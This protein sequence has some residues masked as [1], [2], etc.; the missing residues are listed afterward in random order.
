[1]K[2]VVGV[3]RIHLDPGQGP[4]ADSFYH[5]NESSLSIKDG[6]KVKLSLCLTKLYA[7]KA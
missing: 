2:L 4:V 5:Y 3:D 7:M 1:V 6:I